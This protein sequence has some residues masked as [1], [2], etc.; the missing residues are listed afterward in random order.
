MRLQDFTNLSIIKKLSFLWDADDKRVSLI[1]ELDLY[2][3]WILSIW[4]KLEAS[5][6]LEAFIPASDT[7][8]LKSAMD[9]AEFSLSKTKV[10]LA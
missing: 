7:K 8:E 1:I 9:P 4:N 2:S 5:I 10:V 6:K 3:S